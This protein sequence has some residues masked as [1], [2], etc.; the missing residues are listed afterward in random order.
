MPFFVHECAWFLVRFGTPSCHTLCLPFNPASANV[1]RAST[2]WAEPLT[3]EPESDKVRDVPLETLGNWRPESPKPDTIQVQIG[4]V[5]E[6]GSLLVYEDLD[7]CWRLMTGD[8]FSGK[9]LALLHVG[10]ERAPASSI[11]E[12]SMR[13][14]PSSRAA[15]SFRAPALVRMSVFWHNAGY[16]FV[17][18]HP[19]FSARS[20]GPER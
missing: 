5:S 13:S 16:E 20:A 11:A 10:S 18:L 8:P 6:I 14:C 1:D 9:F 2:C 3:G 17:F 12:G 4:H 7:F 15:F 19:R